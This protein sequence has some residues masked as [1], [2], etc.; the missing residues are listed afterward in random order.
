MQDTNTG[1]VGRVLF[2]IDT[3]DN[4]RPNCHITVLIKL[5]ILCLVFI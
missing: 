4:K 5:Q 3:L 2:K 1:V